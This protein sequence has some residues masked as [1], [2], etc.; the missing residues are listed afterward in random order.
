MF[1]LGASSPAKL[2]TILASAIGQGPSY[3]EVG[4]T[5]EALFPAGYRQV[6]HEGLIGSRADFERAVEGLTHW[7]AHE[8]AGIR[9]FPTNQLITVGATVLAV[10]SI[11]FATMVAPC[12]VVSVI[13]EADKF[14]FAYGT[15]PGHPERGEEA[16]TVER[17]DAGTFF[18]V[19]AFSQP[20]DLLVRLSG[21]FGHVAQQIATRRYITAMRRY[22]RQS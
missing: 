17:R 7:T 2:E 6:K 14:G 11:G 4:A 13:S 3:P 12:R 15:L 9:I 1:L 20:A 8:G 21:P 19:R 5:S 16:F 10:V 22:A 18:S